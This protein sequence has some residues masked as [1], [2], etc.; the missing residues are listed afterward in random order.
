MGHASTAEFQ[1]IPECGRWL[2]SWLGFDTDLV[3]HAIHAG[4]LNLGAGGAVCSMDRSPESK[5]LVQ[6][7]PQMTNHYGTVL[8]CASLYKEER[9]MVKRL[10]RYLIVFTLYVALIQVTIAQGSELY[11]IDAHSQVDHKVVPLKK[12]I[13]IMKQGG[14]SHTI[15][16]ARGKLKGKALRA[17]A[18]QNPEYITP[19]VRT[20]GRPYESGSTKYYEMLEAQVSS[21]GFSAMAEVLLYHARKGNKAPEYVVYPE[22]ERVRVALKYAIDNHWPFVVH[23]EFSSLYGKKKRRFMA[24]LEGMLDQYPEDPFVLTHMGQLRPN[25]CRRLIENHKNIH[26]HTGWTNPAAIKRSYQ[27]W[28]NVFKEKHLAPDWNDLFIQYPERFVFALDNVFAEHWTSSFYVKQMEFW[29]N[30]LA[31]LPLEAAHLIA[32]GNAER[33]WHIAPRN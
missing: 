5:P 31:E 19:A 18:S 16:S 26:F 3:Y 33:L 14:V 28:V 4:N 10:F 1:A 8:H 30:A 23:I 7:H 29:K 17:F 20:K 24:S 2:K 12:V 9:Q 6:I 22:D 27:P 21:R 11:F 15:L 13:S 32:H 25:E